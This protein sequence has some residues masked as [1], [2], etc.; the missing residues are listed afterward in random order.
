MNAKS[1]IGKAQIARFRELMYTANVTMAPNYREVQNNINDVY[2]CFEEEIEP[3]IVTA[4]EKTENAIMWVYAV[5]IVG[6]MF[7]FG[8]ICVRRSK[9][10][11]Q[12]LEAT[13]D[14]TAKRERLASR[15]SFGNGRDFSRQSSHGSQVHRGSVTGGGH[16]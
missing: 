10:E 11:A 7:A 8:F 5:F 15:S 3:D 1:Y 13:E 16:H 14:T 9:K 4:A 12:L 2:A 6:V